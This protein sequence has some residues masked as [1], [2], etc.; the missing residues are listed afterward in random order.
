MVE[1]KIVSAEAKQDIK[2]SPPRRIRNVEPNHYVNYSCDDG[3]GWEIEV[4]LPGVPKGNIQIK[5]LP[6][7][8][9]IQAKRDEGTVYHLTEYFP[10]EVKPDSV[11]SDRKSVV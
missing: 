2:P 10:Y 5:V 9:D 8:Y 1:D 6:E 3:D 4:H 11:Q 7:L